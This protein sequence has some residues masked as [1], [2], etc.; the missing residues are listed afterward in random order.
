ME[1][2]DLCSIPFEGFV[3]LDGRRHIYITD[4]TTG[5]SRW[6]KS[7][8]DYFGLPGEYLDNP[9]E[10]WVE[11]IHPD[12]R[13]M[14]LEDIE[15][16]YNGEKSVHN[17]DYRAK[18]VEGEYV[19]CTC[20]GN[21]VDKPDGTGKFFTGT[22]ENHAISDYYDSVTGLK[23]V[24]AFLS[25]ALENRQVGTE[26]TL[27]IVGINHFSTIN[28]MYSYTYGN[29]CLKT[30]ADDLREKLRS[31]DMI[32]R[33]DGIK[34][35]L[36]LRDVNISYVKNLYNELRDIAH[37]GYDIDNN[38]LSFTL[39]GGVVCVTENSG[40]NYSVQASLIHVFDKSKRSKHG[41]LVIFNEG[42]IDETKETLALMEAVRS[43]VFD[44]MS[45]F[46]LCYQPIID[47]ETDSIS[48]MEALIRWKKEPFGLVPPGIFIPWLETDPCF[49][50]LGEWVLRTAINDAKTI[51][52]TNKNFVVNVN[53]SAEQMEREGFRQSIVDILEEYQFPAENLCIE[54]TERVMSLNIEFLRTELDY[55]RS[56]GI[57]IAL[58]D[59]GTGVS[60]LNLLLELPVD[61]LKID[62]NFVKSIKT[63][64]IEQLMVETISFCAQGMELDICVEGVETEEMKEFLKKYK[65]QKH[66]GYYYSKPVPLEEFKALLCS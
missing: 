52:E 53:V 60:S 58:D 34:F 2:K 61:Y 1:N 28:K 9:V 54:L 31:C 51:I 23:N 29:K 56:L 48:G 27:L 40:T 45:G 6:S 36:V 59:F 13:E 14:F 33:L 50:E 15:A 25:Y 62:R 20:K 26:D 30:F 39:S 18:N 8:V 35:C 38:H 17:I 12:D 24:Y 44:K 5:L 55:F 41:E 42:Q 32:Y 37:Q 43:S 19:V 49:Y 3:D 21:V 47:V 57:K 63:S 65:I 66:Q 7:A 11:H 22:I 16:I 4:M 46:F 64:R 10:I